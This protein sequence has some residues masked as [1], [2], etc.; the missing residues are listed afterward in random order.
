MI[1][2]SELIVC[3]NLYISL[4]LPFIL[5]FKTNEFKRNTFI[6]LSINLNTK[7]GTF[8]F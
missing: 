5:K 3:G 8:L 4:S 2:G 1:I 6:S 7:K